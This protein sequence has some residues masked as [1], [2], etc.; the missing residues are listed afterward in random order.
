MPGK[1]VTGIRASL[2]SAARHELLA[3]DREGGMAVSSE[4]DED[5]REHMTIHLWL[6]E[7]LSATEHAPSMWPREHKGRDE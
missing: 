5:G 2:E 3:S 1:S 6:G 4:I 7:S